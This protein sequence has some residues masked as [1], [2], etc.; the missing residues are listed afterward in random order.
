M[1]SRRPQ[2]VSSHR[3]IHGKFPFGVRCRDG[4]TAHGGQEGWEVLLG[5]RRSGGM[6]RGEVAQGRGRE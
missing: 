1:S 4:V 2:G 5:S 3:G 6:F